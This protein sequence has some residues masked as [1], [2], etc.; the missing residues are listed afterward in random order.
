MNINS[1]KEVH[2]P[3]PSSNSGVMLLLDCDEA[4]DKIFDYTEGISEPNWT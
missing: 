3:T 1:F 4:L 2:I